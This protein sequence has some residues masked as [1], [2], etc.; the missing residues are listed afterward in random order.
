MNHLRETEQID[1]LIEVE[2]VFLNQQ[3]IA[4]LQHTLLPFQFHINPVSFIFLD[5]QI[6]IIIINHKHRYILDILTS[7]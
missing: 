2:I 4:S 5:N 1:V 6:P 3:D 7:H